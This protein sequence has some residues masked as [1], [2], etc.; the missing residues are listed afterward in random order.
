[1]LFAITASRVIFALI[2]PYYHNI[3]IIEG[4][5]IP[6]TIVMGIFL[7][8]YIG[9]K[10]KGN[11]MPNYRIDEWCGALA[12]IEREFKVEWNAGLY[13]LGGKMFAMIGHNKEGEEIISLKNKPEKNEALRAAYADITPGYYLNKAHWISIKLGGDVPEEVM[14][15]LIVESYR[16]I[17]ESLNA[18]ERKAIIGE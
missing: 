11:F 16:C 17:L 10:S 1:V 5:L 14:K 7:I 12:G 3:F 4:I 2:I 6:N 15:E 8:Y 13:K 9:R 18:K